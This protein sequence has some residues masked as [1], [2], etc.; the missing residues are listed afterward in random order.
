[1]M[2]AGMNEWLV[3]IWAGVT[4]PAMLITLAM[5]EGLL[6]AANP[7]YWLRLASAEPVSFLCA[8]VLFTGLSV[9]GDQAVFWVLP[10]VHIALQ[11]MVASA[12]ETIPLAAGAHVLGIYVHS[13]QDDLIE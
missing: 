10:H 9:L 12:V 3:V 5:T 7:L 8:A 2:Q 11:G 4:M 1:M 6:D 13:Y